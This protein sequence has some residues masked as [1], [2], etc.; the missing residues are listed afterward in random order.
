[1]NLFSYIS[2]RF[3]LCWEEKIKTGVPLL[4][5]LIGGQEYIDAQDE[6]SVEQWMKK[7]FMPEVGLYEWNAVDP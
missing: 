6:L 3:A 2:L 1:M 4:P 5:M 7:N